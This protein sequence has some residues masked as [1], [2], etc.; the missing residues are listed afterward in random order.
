MFLI[1]ATV[2]SVNLIDGIDGLSSG[3]TLIYAFTMAIVFIY[4]SE[5][6]AQSGQ[7]EQTAG[8]EGLIV[9]A[10]RLRADA[11]DF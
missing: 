5:I 7:I 4:L 10:E 6:G 1:I 11:L 2:N 3:V 9:F 8:Y